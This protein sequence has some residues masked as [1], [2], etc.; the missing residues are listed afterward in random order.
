MRQD[1]KQAENVIA[2]PL[3]PL[4]F[5]SEELSPE[6]QETIFEEFNTLSVVYQ[7]PASLFVESTAYHSAASEAGSPTAADA[8]AASAATANGNSAALV[9]TTT[10]L[11]DD[12]AHQEADLLDLESS[13]APSS[14]TTT[15][16]ATAA[17]AATPANVMDSLL[18][19]D[20]GAPTASSGGGS[21]LSLNPTAKVMPGLFQER[22]RS[23]PPAHQY[24]DTLNMATVAAF[25]ANQHKDFCAHMA[26]ANIMTMASGGQPPMYR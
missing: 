18:D 1:V 11:L 21:S 26:Q 14:A 10:N 15:S 4:Q 25:A 16:A 9:D 17:V 24:S 19:L 13:T 3:E 2:G 12:A 8:H 6:V 23:L 7:Q 5:F 20:L 22:W